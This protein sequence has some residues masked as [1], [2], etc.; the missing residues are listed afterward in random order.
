MAR[1]PTKAQP[2]ARSYDFTM[3]EGESPESYYKRLAKAAD[4]RLLR[5]ER[6]AGTEGYKE[7]KGFSYARAIE[8]IQIYVP[9]ATRFNTKMV[10]DKDT[11]LVDQ[12]IL[13]ERT[14][15]VIDFLSAPTSTKYGIDTNFKNSIE[16]INKNFHTGFTWEDAAAFFIKE[17]HTGLF[18]QVK[19]SGLTLRAIGKIRSME[20]SLGKG[21]L[22]NTDLKIAGPEKDAIIKILSDRRRRYI[23]THEY[24][25]DF[26]KEV[27]NA[28]D[29]LNKKKW[30]KKFGL[31]PEEQIAANQ[32]SM[33]KATK[34]KK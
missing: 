8:D 9:G 30:M 32:K 31:N 1:R 26:K 29:P 28:L 24:T 18:K 16:T 3:R 33:K 19:D 34:K 13:K 10:V 22:K 15:S 25:D 17:Q 7:I 12:R 4:Q 20:D 27:L 2:T 11:G 14:M 6:L 21:I 5:I 23:G